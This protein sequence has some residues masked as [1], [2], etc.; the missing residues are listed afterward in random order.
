VMI[1]LNNEYKYNTLQ[2]PIVDDEL[3]KAAGEVKEDGEFK[4]QS[5]VVL[6]HTFILHA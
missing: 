6:F 2:I 4:L 1:C 3:K 5:T